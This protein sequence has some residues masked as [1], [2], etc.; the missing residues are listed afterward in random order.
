MEHRH[1][2][3]EAYTAAAIDDIIARGGRSDWAGLRDAARADATVLDR[4]LRV[5]DAR[6]DAPYA[7]RY[8]FWRHYAA[9]RRVA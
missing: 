3:H 7:Q 1:L 8:R 2:N 9:R 5:C 6:S 4:I